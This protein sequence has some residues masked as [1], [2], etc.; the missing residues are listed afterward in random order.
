MKPPF[1]V[2]QFFDVFARYNNAVWP[3]QF[4]LLGLGILAVFLVHL[5]PRRTG[6]MVAAILAS[7]WGWMAVAFFL[8]QFSRISPG[9]WFFGFLFALQAVL[10]AW[11]GILEG[12]LEFGPSPRPWTVVGWLLVSYG[13]V[14][15][16]LLGA[17]IGHEYM[18]SPTFGVPCPTTIFT[19]GLLCFARRP[20]PRYILAIPI[21]WTAIG[22]SAAFFLEVPQDLGLLDA[23]AVGVAMVLRL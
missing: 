1:S 19:F 18:H 23:G 13:L 17:W 3:M 8:A 6:R 16:T 7:L 20:V 2:G 14:I 9:A 4:L 12:R 10:F 21:L 5:C 11:L 15:Y 22:G